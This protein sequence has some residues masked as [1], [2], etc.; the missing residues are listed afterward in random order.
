MN[1]SNGLM[2]RALGAALLTV[3]GTVACYL[4]F[5]PAAAPPPGRATSDP[6]LGPRPGAP[7]GG[8]LPRPVLAAATV[9]PAPSALVPTASDAAG[10]AEAIDDVEQARPP[11][12]DEPTEDRFTAF[13]RRRV[14][15][16]ERRFAVQA[17]D[18]AWEA[19]VKRAVTRES[20]RVQGGRLDSNGIDCAESVCRVTFLHRA[21]NAP[22]PDSV[23]DMIAHIS[24]D[25]GVEVSARDDRTIVYVERKP[26]LAVPGG[27]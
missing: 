24:N 16:L 2:K 8:R 23:N 21:G 7:L 26:P 14:E 12:W 19:E 20:A 6:G 17:R 13:R 10:D 22:T 1:R 4:V 27:G 3:T 9:Q 18:P 15:E 25:F 11:G 5:F